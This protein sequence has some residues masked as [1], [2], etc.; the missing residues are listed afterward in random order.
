[1]PSTE[2]K[3]QAQHSDTEPNTAPITV[4]LNGSGEVHFD[5]TDEKRT[6]FLP[7]LA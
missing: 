1:M 5:K 4:K 3:T 2:G 6:V 7:S